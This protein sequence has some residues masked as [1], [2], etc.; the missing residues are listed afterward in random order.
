MP[1]MTQPPIPEQPVVPISPAA[2]QVAP[3]RRKRRWP[4]IAGSAAVLTV[5]AVLGGWYAA[6]PNMAD[7]AVQTCQNLV[8]DKLKAPATAQFVDV[9]FTDWQGGHWTVNGQVDA[10][11]GFGALV[12]GPF[13]C[14]LYTPDGREWA[15]N[16]LKVN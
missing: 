1:G 13:S 16:S 5:L 10:Q 4:W 6:Q 9:T 8:R 12:R 11:N 14:E 2:P 3:V 15:V 7:R